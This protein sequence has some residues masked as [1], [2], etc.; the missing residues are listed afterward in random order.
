MVNGWGTNINP[1]FDR[2]FTDRVFGHTL[3]LGTPPNLDVISANLTIRLRAVA[4]TT[5]NDSIG[6]YDPGSNTTVWGTSLAAASGTAWA[7]GTPSTLV[8]PLPAAVLATLADGT[9]DVVVEDDTSVDFMRLDVTVCWCL[10][11]AVLTGG[12]ADNFA[13]PAEPKVLSPGLNTWLASRGVLG[14]RDFDESNT[15]FWFGHSFSGVYPVGTGETRPICRA[16][17]EIHVVPDPGRPGNDTMALTF[18]DPVTGADLVPLPWWSFFGT[19]QGVPNLGLGTWTFGD[20]AAVIT[21]D[22][23]NLPNGGANILPLLQTY[24]WLDVVVQ[25]DTM[26]DYVTLTITN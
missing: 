16:A 3:Q 15:D 24:G 8:L 19:T 18:V 4:G 1:L 5:S 22:L 12:I 9:L 20:P 14:V 23:A 21:L 6:F 26:V 7:P 25:D 11:D 13:P 10:P 17:L 2:P